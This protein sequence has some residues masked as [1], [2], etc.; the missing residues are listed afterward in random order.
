MMNDQEDP[1]A[2][3]GKMGAQPARG[4]SPSGTQ[5]GTVVVNSL[6][7]RKDHNTAAEVVAGLTSGSPVTVYETWTDGKNTWAR[8]GPDQWAA[9]VYEGETYIKLDE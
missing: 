9:L 8:L 7:I 6:R 2:P 3:P 1:K 5:T 4:Q